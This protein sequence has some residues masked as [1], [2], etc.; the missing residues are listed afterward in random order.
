M[1]FD[2]PLAGEIWASKYRFAPERDGEGDASVEQGTVKPNAP[3][4]HF[5]VLLGREPHT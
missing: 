2:S 3:S 1:A 5:H 4:R